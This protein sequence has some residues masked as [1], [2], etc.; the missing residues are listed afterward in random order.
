MQSSDSG[1]YPDE[2]STQLVLK[3][4]VSSTEDPLTPP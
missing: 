2:N 1:S 3:I 4:S